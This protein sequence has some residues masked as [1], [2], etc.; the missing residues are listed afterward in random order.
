MQVQCKDSEQHQ[1][2]SLL[3]TIEQH[4]FAHLST[5]WSGGTK[6][7]QELQSEDISSLIQA[8]RSI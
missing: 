1:S 3:Y 5:E 6:N 7:K 4:A 8:P 2:Y